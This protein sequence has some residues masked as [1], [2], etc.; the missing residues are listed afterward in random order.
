MRLH[1]AG[2]EDTR[3]TL[4]PLAGSCAAD[5]TSKPNLL[6]SYYYNR[7]SM[8]QK[9]RERWRVLYDKTDANWIMDSGLF[10]LMFGAGAGKKYSFDELKAYTVQYIKYLKEFSYRHVI[11]EMDVHKVLGL[12]A[13]TELRKYI[14]DNW[15]VEKTIFVWHVEEDINGLIEL[16][17][18]YPYIA[19]SV[20]ELR[21]IAKKR[22]LKLDMLLNNLL[23]RIRKNAS[24]KPKVHLL[25][26][27]Q[28]DLMYNSNYYS[29]DSTS[30]QSQLR[31]GRF[32]MFDGKK[33]VAYDKN[34]EVMQKTYQRQE[35]LI[36][37]YIDIAK[38]QIGQ[39]D[40]ETKPYDV[41]GAM[42]ACQHKRFEMTINNKYYGGAK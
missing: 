32:Q 37:T 38:H 36:R 25:G 21:I 1:L 26:C 6:C 9:E 23:A 12:D 13:L 19:L 2:A 20:P 42:S 11:V 27:T 5:S 8:G 30:W 3:F 35:N 34:S 10:T 29:T 31:F 14:E 28:P 41:R 7:L 4:M 17:N 24:K 39:P 33:F 16:A 15:P 40:L 18:K 22:K